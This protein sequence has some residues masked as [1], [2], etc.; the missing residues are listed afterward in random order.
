MRGGG[1]DVSAGAPECKVPKVDNPLS[2]Q[3]WNKAFK[4]LDC[5]WQQPTM[6]VVPKM[7]GL[8]EINGFNNTINYMSQG[9]NGAYM[10]LRGRSDALNA[11]IDGKIQG[12]MDWSQKPLLGGAKRKA[13]KRKSSKKAPKPKRKSSRK[14]PKRKSSSRVTRM[15]GGGGSDWMSTVQSRG[16]A[17]APDKYWGLDGKTWFGQF[18]NPADYIANS[19][20][21]MGSSEL[22]A[23]PRVSIP[24]GFDQN[25][26]MHQIIGSSAGDLGTQMINNSP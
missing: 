1:A 20:L 15:R 5:Y 12:V 4:E 11:A 19:D 13:S 7:G 18:E 22:R 24:T 2:P 26:Q 17:A 3:S 9:L 10:N 21:R 16:N 14:A 23:Q 8:S 6:E 25:A